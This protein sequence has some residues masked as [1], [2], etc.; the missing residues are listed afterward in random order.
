MAV[1]LEGA[2][3][4]E[5]QELAQ[6]PAPP[7]SRLLDPRL[8]VTALITVILVVGYW[9]YHILEIRSLAVA[10]LAAVATETV[11]SRALRGR[12]A[13]AQSAY[14]SGVSMALL[15]KPQGPLLWPFAIG[16]ALAIL[17]KYV[18]TRRGRHLWNPTNFAISALVLLAPGSVAI[19]SHEMGNSLATNLVIWTM[20]LLI[21]S[22]VR[23]LHVTLSYAAVFAALAPLRAA[24]TG[25][26]VLVEI[27]P[28]TGPMY[29]LFVFF[30]IT[31][32]RTTVGTRRGRMAVAAAVAVVEFAIRLANDFHLGFAA[33][34]ASAPP[35]FA[36][37]IVGPIAMWLDLGRRP[38]ASLKTGAPGVR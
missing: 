20:G 13:N 11:L 18:L 12:F 6:P 3:A 14:I 25:V 32:P 26:P 29:Q 22:R 10:L 15:T 33:P 1:G 5:A 37:A 24:I 9:Q 30:M 34:L 38:V 21:V 4:A 31:D 16:S 7:R 23:L 36:L 2:P 27:A 19:L 8:L 35:I 28:I 17:S